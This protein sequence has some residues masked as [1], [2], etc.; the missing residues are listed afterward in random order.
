MNNKYITKISVLSLLLPFLMA[1]ILG[2]SGPEV[3]KNPYENV[4]WPSINNYKMNLHAHTIKSDG[5]AEPD[6]LIYMYA[7]AGYDILAITDHDN[8]YTHREGERDIMQNYIHRD[9]RDRVPTAE[10]TWP[11]TRWIDEKPS[12]IWVYKGRES[13][14]YYPDLGNRGMLAI[15]GAELTTHPHMLNLFTICG[16]PD[17]DQTDDERIAC[18]EKWEGLSY[19]LHPTDYI[20]GGRWEAQV[21]DTSFEEAVNY[22]ADHI[23]RHDAFIGIETQLE[24]RLERDMKLLDTLLVRY[25]R[26]HDIFFKGSSDKHSTSVSE[27]EVMTL[28]LAE[29]LTEDAVRHALTNG[30]K[31]VG[32]R[33]DPLPEFHT[34]EVDEQRNRISVNASNYE[35]ITWIKNGQEYTRGDYLDYS[36]IRDSIVRFQMES[37]GVIFYSQ[38]FYIR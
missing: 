1:N 22:F 28:V 6:H 3:I 35:E 7:D 18:I 20:P 11:W 17:R 14:A 26:D 16:F 19:W 36:N 24:G 37:G 12:K 33:V 5:R 2:D 32:S 29:E 13:S 30:H 9:H 34:I 10:P 23:I 38:A 25:Y 8:Y 27:N 31:I 4:N 21:F 15:R